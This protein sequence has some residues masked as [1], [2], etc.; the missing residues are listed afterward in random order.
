MVQPWCPAA[1]RREQK[2]GS[3][4]TDNG[5][6]ESATDGGWPLV[7][8]WWDRSEDRDVPPTHAIRWVE[9][10]GVEER[11]SGT[12][13]VSKR[14][15]D[16]TAPDDPAVRTELHHELERRLGTPIRVD[17]ALRH[18]EHLRVDRRLAVRGHRLTTLTLHDYGHDLAGGVAVRPAGDRWRGEIVVRADLTAN[19]RDQLLV[20]AENTLDNL[21]PQP[22]RLDEL[23]W[24]STSSGGWQ[25]LLYATE[26]T[27]N[28][29]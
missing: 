23:G 28:A 21:G 12:S 18:L 24:T 6:T 1:G 5:H 4:L 13:H 22:K 27:A 8:W 7:V 29:T 10:D 15:C 25:Q 3:R 2:R 26:D 20:W 14:T 11:R 19:A 17:H 9:L 16:P